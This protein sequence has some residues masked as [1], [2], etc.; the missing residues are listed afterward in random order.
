MPGVGTEPQRRDS[1][2]MRVSWAYDRA[3]WLVPRETCGTV[4]TERS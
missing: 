1:D 2:E 3:S 4:G